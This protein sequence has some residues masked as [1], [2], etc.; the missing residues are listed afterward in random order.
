MSIDVKCDTNYAGAWCACV[1][2]QDARKNIPKEQWKWSVSA[3]Y[4]N[5]IRHGIQGEDLMR[6]KNLPW[7]TMV[8]LNTS[9]GKFKS[10]FLLTETVHHLLLLQYNPPTTFNLTRQT[11]LQSTTWSSLIRSSSWRSSPL[12]PKPSNTSTAVEKKAQV[13]AIVRLPTNTPFP[14]HT[15]TDHSATKSK[16]FLRW[17]DAFVYTCENGKWRKTETCDGQNIHNDIC[18]PYLLLF[19]LL[20]VVMMGIANTPYRR[21]AR[22]RTWQNS[23]TLR[24]DYGASW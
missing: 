18:E 6:T 22:L 15:N 17:P 2:I 21:P 9:C 24:F 10:C 8:Q 16:Y 13:N 12:R 19:D 14:L 23:R 3:S 7:C 1:G 4:P 20:L 5:G 11:S